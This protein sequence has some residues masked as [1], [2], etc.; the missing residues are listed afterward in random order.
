MT[1]ENINLISHKELYKTLERCCGAKHWLNEMVNK[2]PYANKKELFY[3]AD[4]IWE[5]ADKSCWL[6]AFTHH[7]KI[8]DIDILENKFANTKQWAEGEQSGVEKASRE[9][10]QALAKGNQ[11]YEDKFGYIFIVCATGKSATEML[12]LLND[13]LPNTEE[14]EILI[15]MKEQQKITTIRLEKLLEL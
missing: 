5:N 14:E 9:I 1:L 10:L 11:A 6:D 13:R 4:H 8:G 3:W 7:P 12:D 2:A 15:A